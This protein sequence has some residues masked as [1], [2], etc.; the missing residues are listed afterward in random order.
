MIDVKQ[1]IVFKLG[2]TDYGFPI[3]SV[4]EIIKNVP[5]MN[6]PNSS[7]YVDGVC[8]LRGKVYTILNIKNILG[9]D[10]KT[11]DN[12]SSYI[13][14]SNDYDAGIAVDEIK[15][16]ITPS[17]DDIVAID[18]LVG[19][20]NNQNIMYVVKNKNDLICVLNY[21]KILARSLLDVF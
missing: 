3:D 16:I 2:D 12:K 13:I 15:M 6:I 18:S 4:D 5:V 20:I 14:T 7:N 17:L 8:N 10:I 19:Y 1:V 9:L 21:K 11:I